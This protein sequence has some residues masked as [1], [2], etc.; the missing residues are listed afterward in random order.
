MIE[1]V[2][3][4][5]TNRKIAHFLNMKIRESMTRSSTWVDLFNFDKIECSCD[6]CYDCVDALS[7]SRSNNRKSNKEKTKIHHCE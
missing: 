1:I 6:T 3:H 4:A 2:K 7:S 5:L